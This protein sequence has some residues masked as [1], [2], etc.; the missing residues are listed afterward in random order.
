MSALPRPTAAA[1]DAYRALTYDLSMWA[2]TAHHLVKERI[3]AAVEAYGEPDHAGEPAWEYAERVLVGGQH[4]FP[5]GE[6]IHD[7]LDN[8]RGYDHV[9]I[10]Y[11][12]DL[13]QAQYVTGVDFVGWYPEWSA[14]GNHYRNRMAHVTVPAW[15][16]TD[17]AAVD[18]YR[19]QTARLAE[20][21]RAEQARFK[22]RI[23]RIVERTLA[24]AERDTAGSE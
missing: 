6:C 7:D 12:R 17:P 14:D 23:A 2:S 13:D 3:A 16:I 19:Q 8:N 11:V 15:V 4:P 10:G 21:V 22:A 9:Q 18:R 20:Q 1:L 24:L 5:E